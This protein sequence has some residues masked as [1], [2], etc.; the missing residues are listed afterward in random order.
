MLIELLRS[1]VEVQACG[2]W[3]VEVGVFA[4]AKNLAG[5]ISCV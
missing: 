1:R 2:T 5:V 4:A 3:E